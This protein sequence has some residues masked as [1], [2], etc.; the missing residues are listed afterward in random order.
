MYNEEKLNELKENLKDNFG[1]IVNEIVLKYVEE[2]KEYTKQHVREYIWSLLP[3]LIAD[4]DLSEYGFDTE[5]DFYRFIDTWAVRNKL[6]K[7]FKEELVT[8]I[9]GD[10]Q[11]QNQQ[12]KKAIDVIVKLLKKSN[13]YIFDGYREAKEELE[14]LG[15]KL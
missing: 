11:R 12:Y 1:N 14:Y 13:E 9:M 4:K 7:D 3:A 6:R 10:L 5:K 2:V 8:E 15:I